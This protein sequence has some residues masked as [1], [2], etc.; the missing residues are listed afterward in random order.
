M[1][2][3][4]FLPNAATPSILPTSSSSNSRSIAS[5]WFP[6]MFGGAASADEM[7]QMNQMMQNPKHWILSLI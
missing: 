3:L 2:L 5:N 7:A 1:F 6:G 4:A